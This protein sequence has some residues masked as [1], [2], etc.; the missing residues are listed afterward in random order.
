MLSFLKINVFVLFY[1]VLILEFLICTSDRQSARVIVT[2]SVVTGFNLGSQTFDNHIFVQ[3]VILVP[4][5][6]DNKN[7]NKA[8]NST[9]S[10]ICK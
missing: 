6:T 3:P 4:T 5:S 8:G 9:K 2:A 10:V 1:S 7:N